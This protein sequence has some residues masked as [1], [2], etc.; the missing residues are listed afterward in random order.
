MQTLDL[1]SIHYADEPDK[2]Y[3]EGLDRVKL[4]QQ[5]RELG[6]RFA[7]LFPDAYEQIKTMDDEDFLIFKGGLRKERKGEFAGEDFMEKFGCI[8]MPANLMHV[9]MIAD[10]FKVPFGLAFCRLVEAGRMKIDS[11]R[12]KYVKAE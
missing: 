3:C 9:G 4:P 5:L 8:L 1:Q 12:A 2:T 10:K 6:E 11:G 7:S